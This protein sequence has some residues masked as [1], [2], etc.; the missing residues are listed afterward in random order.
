MLFARA[1]SN[2]VNGSQLQLTPEDVQV[3][4]TGGYAALGSTNPTASGA[5][6]G[7]LLNLS[8]TGSPQSQLEVGCLSGAPGD[9]SIATSLALTSDAGEVLG[10]GTVGCGSGNNCP[11]GS[12]IQCALVEKVNA[13]G[14]LEWARVYKAAANG[15]AIRTIR[16]TRDGGLI[17]AGTILGADNVPGGL[18]LKLDSLGNVQWTRSIGPAGSTQVLLNDVQQTSDGGYVVTGD[19]ET[20]RG[21]ALVVKLDASGNIVWERSF[22]A[23]SSTSSADSIVTSADGGLLVG[24]LWDDSVNG[25]CCSGALL[26][27][28]DSSGNI[29]WQEALSGGLYC[30]FNGFSETCVNLAATVISAR[31][32]ADGGYVLSGDENLV[33]SDGAPIEPWIAKVDASGNLL[34]QHLYYQTNPATGRPLS[35]YF[36][37]TAVASDGGF[38]SVGFT[39]NLNNGLGEMLGVSTDGNGVVSSTCGDLRPA[40]TLNPIN[41]SLSA[42]GQ[43]LP[44]ATAVAPTSNSPATTAA[45]SVSTQSDC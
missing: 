5:S 41:P 44:V 45:T 28:L 11:E 30:F 39:E 27:K 16:Q 22:G 33:M 31:Q 15:S 3:T 43:S 7:W 8:S 6:V 25:S 35:E 21:S 26:L 17:A 19:L 4:P 1:Y 36:A 9:Y 42:A 18:V 34:W 12:G 10:G 14:A 13:T 29:Q 20:P 23:S 38:F 24:G 40:T 2:I 37:S 32:T